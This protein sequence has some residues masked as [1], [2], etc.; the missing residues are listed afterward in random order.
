MANNKP[1]IVIVG[2]AGDK[3]LYINIFQNGEPVKNTLYRLQHPGMMIVEQWNNEV[4]KHNGDSIKLETVSRTKKFF[5]ECVFPVSEAI[6]PLE[7]SLVESY[8]KNE[9]GK[10]TPDDISPKY[11]SLWQRV[12]SRFLDGDLWNDIPESGIEP[13]KEGSGSGSRAKAK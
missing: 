11:H 7:E 10:L 13:V 1:E 12:S 5:K 6:T 9:S 2:E 8:G 3:V 4:L